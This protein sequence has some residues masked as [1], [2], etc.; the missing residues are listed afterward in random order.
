[1][2]NYSIEKHLFGK[3]CGDVVEIFH[4]S[5]ATK[6]TIR[7]NINSSSTSNNTLSSL[8]L[9]IFKEQD[10]DKRINKIDNYFLF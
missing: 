7:H 2:N 8:L 10:Q 9:S 3:N 4:K 5:P 1:M 6:K